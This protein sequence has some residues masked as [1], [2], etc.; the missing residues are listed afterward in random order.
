MYM[1]ARHRTAATNPHRPQQQPTTNK[2]ALASRAQPA[3]SG[4]GQWLVEEVPGLEGKALQEAATSLLAA[5]GDPAVVVL[6]S[7]GEGDA[8]KVSF[9][10]AVSP[11]AVSKGL[12]AGKLV[13]SVAKVCGGGGGG[14]PSLAQA[15]GKDAS[16]L[17]EALETARGLV[18]E[19]I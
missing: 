9:V 5:L 17:P 19:A 13:G 3:P 14:K 15:G 12:Q 6:A 18:V 4:A 11:S 16:K 8:A 10:A 1:L 2:Q 7:K